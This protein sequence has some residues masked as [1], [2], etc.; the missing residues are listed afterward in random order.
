[1][2]EVSLMHHR[3][4]QTLLNT[5]IREK[6]LVSV[7]LIE[8]LVADLHDKEFRTKRFSSKAYP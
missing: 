7:Q 6:E 1:M 8:L 4:D 2:G 5:L 3:Q